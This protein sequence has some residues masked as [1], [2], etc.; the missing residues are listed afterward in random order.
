M[1]NKNILYLSYDGM[2]DPLGQSQVLPYIIGLSKKGFCF[3]L[4]SFEKPS[5]FA[6]NKS[7][8][9]NICIEN[10]IDWQPIPFSSKPPFLSKYYDIYMMERKAVNL[11]KHK[12]FA[13]V[14]CRSYISAGIG[15]KLKKRFGIK[16]F[17]DMRGFW[18]DERVDGGM[19]NLNNPFFKL[20]YKYYKNQEA[21]YITNADAIVSLT[22]A[23]KEEIQNWDSYNKNNI[24]VIP[25]SAD[26]QLFPVNN[27]ERKAL[28][29]A[30]LGINKDSLVISYLGSI[31]TWYLL[32]EMLEAYVFIKNKFPNSRFLFIT[33]EPPEM[34]YE[35]ADKL[36]LQRE[37]FIIKFAKRAEVALFASASDIN[38]FFIKQS[39]SK[40][41]SSPT[42]LG[43][44]LALGIPVVCNSRVGDVKDI[45]EF[46]ESG[47]TIDEFNK[48]SYEKIVDH[49]P[50][51]LKKD[52][53]SIRSKAE[54]YYLL[55]N[56]IEKYCTLYQE[57]L[58]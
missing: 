15:V 50:E 52:S 31:G 4:I 28:A 57:V 20:A 19:W 49:I 37:E 1:Q 38:L 17:F 10:G 53:V 39:Y 3:T 14:H 21:S 5:R 45:I 43:E 16:Y 47:I 26:F 58:Q 56:A 13:M 35:K 27:G 9:E 51:L 18:V 54:E 7:L 36:G 40:I 42:K 33:P 23:G 44:V 32:D 41:A 25:C 30:L 55:D 6:A 22:E 46:T 2:T 34:V 29:R 8:I 24:G 11:H 48:E 12:K